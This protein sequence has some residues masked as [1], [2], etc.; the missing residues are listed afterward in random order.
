MPL[1]TDT[2]DFEEKDGIF[3]AIERVCDISTRNYIKIALGDF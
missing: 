2:S 1:P 3:G